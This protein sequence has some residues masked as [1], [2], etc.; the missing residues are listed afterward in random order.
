MNRIPLLVA[1]AIAASSAQA[2]E[3]LSFGQSQA[4]TSPIVGTVSGGVT[5]IMATDAPISVT[6]CLMCKTIL[7]QEFLTM[8]ATS[9]G[10]AATFQGFAVESFKGTFEIT[11][12]TGQNILSGVFNDATFGAGTSLTLSASNAAKAESLSLTSNILPAPDLAGSEAMS[13]SLADV[14]PTVTVVNGTLA[15]FTGSVAG[16]FSGTPASVDEPGTVPLA[17]LGLAGLGLMLWRKNR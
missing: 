7:G 2:T 11:S 1:A 16:T 17:F 8:N 15:P 12:A 6:S 14:T 3:V 10:T 4:G 13:L 9:V 5:T